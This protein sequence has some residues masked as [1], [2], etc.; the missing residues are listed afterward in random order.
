MYQDIFTQNFILNFLIS[1]IFLAFNTFFSIVV[2][3]KLKG[4]KIFFFDEFQEIVI[5]LVI[6][7]TY[8]FLFNLLILIDEYQKLNSL[9]YIIFFFQLLFV[10]KEVPNLKKITLKKNELSN[11]LKFLILILFLF[12]LI[13]ILPITDADSIALHQNLANQIYVEGLK[14]LN[15]DKNVS[16]TVFSNTHTLLILSPI[17]QSDNLGA[18]LNL[19]LLVLFIFSNLKKNENFLSILFASPL[20]IYFVSAQKLQLFFGIIFLLLFILIHKDYIKSKLEIFL[21]ILLLAFYASGNLSYSL[22]AIPLFAY[23][24]SK[25]IKD[26]KLIIKFS[27]ICLAI[28]ILPYLLIKHIYFQNILAPFLDEYLG[29]NNPL[30]NAY[31]FSIRS[32]DGWMQDPTNLRLYLKPFFSFNLS[33]L[34]VSLGI[35]FLLMIFDFK[36][37]KKLYFFPIII[38]FL[39]LFTGQILPRYYFEAF[40][41]L[42]YFFHYKNFLIKWLIISQNLIVM[43]FTL[44]FLYLSYIENNVIIDKKSYMEKFSYSYF[45]SLENK[46]FNFNGNVLD[47]SVGRPSLFFDKNFFSTRSIG[48]MNIYNEDQNNHLIEFLKRNSIR[49]IITSD[50]KNLPDCLN[51]IK[52]NSIDRKRAV[53]NFLKTNKTTTQ[54]IFLVKSNNC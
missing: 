11:N 36:L 23:F 43:S 12:Y 6:F 33:E 51:L 14:E 2:S 20:I 26:W 37:L 49:Y 1:F 40:L 52:T 29:V 13:S 10:L 48:I 35:I 19:F 39:V 8:S 25:K 45:N 27:L 46:K 7:I 24:F 3:S 9:F 30:Y 42:A 34:S 21:T 4:K 17:L 28:V 47:F 5:F 18:Q 44:I 32:T 15:F 41:I 38:I 31:A 50:M 54:D 22:F 16:F 53:R